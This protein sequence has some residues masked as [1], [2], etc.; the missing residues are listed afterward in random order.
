MATSKAV[1]VGNVTPEGEQI[2]KTYLKQF[3]PEAK[4]EPLKSV[5]IK[6]TI[7]NRA[8]RPDV[9]LVILDESLYAVCQGVSDDI[10]KVLNM[11]K[12]HKYLND[13]DLTQFL[14]SRFGRLDGSIESVEI[15]STPKDTVVI[16]DE[17]TVVLGGSSATESFDSD[18]SSEKEAR[19]SELKDKLAQSEMLVKN[20]TA[21]LADSQNASDIAPFIDKIKELERQIAEKDAE[22]QQQD[23]KNYADSDKLAQADKVLAEQESLKAELKTLKENCSEFEFE[24]KKAKEEKDQVQADYDSLMAEVEDLRK[25]SDNLEEVTASLQEMTER[26][27]LLESSNSDANVLQAKIEEQNN[28]ISEFDKVKEE[29]NQK[30]LDVQNLQVDLDAKTSKVEEL[31][32]KLNDFSSLIDEKDAEIQKKQEEYDNLLAEKKQSDEQ[33]ETLY[34]QITDLKGKLSGLTLTLEEKS[35]EIANL[36]KTQTETNDTLTRLQDELDNNGGKDAEI[37]DLQN[38]L[39]ES[40]KTVTDLQNTINELNN[41]IA[42]NEGTI[43]A[44]KHLE[45]KL[46]AENEKSTEALTKALQDNEELSANVEEN[47]TTITSLETQVSDLQQELEEAKNNNDGALA[48]KESELEQLRTDKCKLENEVTSLRDSLV[49]SKADSDTIKQLNDDLLE[50]RRKN[51]RISS[52]LEVLRKGSELVGSS[53]N[54]VE[55]NRL[56]KE[57]NELKIELEN[58]PQLDSGVSA[59][60]FEALRA[61]AADMEVDL[62]V[63][64]EEINEYKNGVFG[65][66]ANAAGLKLAYNVKVFTPERLNSKCV[67]VASG[68]VE[69]SLSLYKNLKRTCTTVN[70]KSYLIIDLVTD[71]SIDMA[72]GITNIQSPLKWL[73]GEQPYQNFVADTQFANVKVLSTGLAYLNDLALLNVDW[74]KRIE[75]VQGQYDVVI[76]NV[77]CLNNF[78]AKILFNSFANIMTGHIIVKGSPIN[79]RTVILLLT[80]FIDTKV[81]KNIFVSCVN[82][83][84]TSARPLYQ[85]LTQKCQAQILKDADLLRL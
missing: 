26:C 22:L 25:A 52:E 62:A 32:T 7:R 8:S 33:I 59:D 82:F 53:D 48:D 63:K 64:D 67:V 69:S 12:V 42:E 49:E 68:S 21:Q 13:D 34:A 18:N 47:K 57:I 79:L 17:D 11:P 3:L 41:T 76:F 61:K 55:I 51:A 39:A 6:G 85:K 73:T 84:T 30:E 58:K 28:V 38:V 81:L 43:D 14:I 35:N 44:Y 66:L 80:G 74:V 4:I 56:K 27:A 15:D 78:V 20:L 24:L 65:Q 60:E 16:S 2:L 45:E 19:I 50:E 23:S 72:F 40:K 46:K 1:L 10:D 83:D 29:L 75:E 31:T 77:G 9:A 37:S 54:I 36:E 5:G 71:T 70:N